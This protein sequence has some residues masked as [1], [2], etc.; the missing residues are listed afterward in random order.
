MH[1]HHDARRIPERFEIE[2]VLITAGNE[3]GDEVPPYS[4]PHKWVFYDTPDEPPE[5]DPCQDTSLDKYLE[6]NHRTRSNR[7]TRLHDD[8]D[9][10]EHSG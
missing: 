5:Y 4:P 8:E 3:A 9:T 10:S 6:E 1:Q 2:R 7:T